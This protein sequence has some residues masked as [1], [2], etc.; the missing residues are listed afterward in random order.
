MTAV[1]WA[2]LLLPVYL[3]CEASAS[4]WKDD[5]DGQLSTAFAR[6]RERQR[7]EDLMQIA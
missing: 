1:E 3:I 6:D 4:E 5:D 7:E 2:A